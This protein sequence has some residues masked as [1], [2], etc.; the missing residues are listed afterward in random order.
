V[1][2]ILQAKERFGLLKPAPVDVESAATHVKT[3]EHLALARELAQKSMTLVRDPQGLLPLK[4]DSSPLIVEPTAVRD[5]TQYIGLNSTI[6]VV[7]TQLKN[8]EIEEVIHAAENG[9]LVII[10]V[11]D[12][13]TNTKQ[14]KLIK[15]LVEAGNPVIAIPH[16]NPFDAALL[17]EN[18]TILVSY[19]FNPPI[20]EALTKVLVG[21]SQPIGVLPVTL[22]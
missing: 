6:M 2:R 9:R 12:L 7:E 22:P 10:P 16:R 14:L 15:E 21:Q 20:R 5:L 4:A 13:T 8:S 18:V 3:A 19:G 17:P 11:N 1:R